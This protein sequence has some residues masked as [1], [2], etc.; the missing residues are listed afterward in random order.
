MRIRIGTDPLA[1]SIVIKGGAPRNGAPLARK[2]RERE[3]S[4][5]FTQDAY[6]SLVTVRTTAHFKSMR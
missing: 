3:Q 2:H 4:Q 5:K 6:T 1:V